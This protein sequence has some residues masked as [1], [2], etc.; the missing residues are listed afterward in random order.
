M[1]ISGQYCT[2]GGTGTVTVLLVAQP[3]SPKA[4][5]VTT[6]R[7]KRRVVFMSADEVKSGALTVEEFNFQALLRLEVY[8]PNVPGEN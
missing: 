6:A 1:R 5:A 7:I 4:S 2:G 8:Q 3:A